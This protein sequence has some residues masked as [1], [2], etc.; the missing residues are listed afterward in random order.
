MVPKLED[1]SQFLVVNGC[2]EHNRDDAEKE[3]H[4]GRWNGTKREFFFTDPVILCVFS[5]GHP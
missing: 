2:F 3:K 4:R 5:E 1:D